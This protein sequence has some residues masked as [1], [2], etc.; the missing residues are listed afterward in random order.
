VKTPS[1]LTGRF[2]LECWD[3]SLGIQQKSAILPGCSGANQ[4]NS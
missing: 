4:I 2:F 1:R 3:E